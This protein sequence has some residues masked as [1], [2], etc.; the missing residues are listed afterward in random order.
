MDRMRMPMT[1]LT[2]RNLL[3]TLVVPGLG[4]VAMPWWILTNHGAAPPATQWYAV[5]VIV[6]GAAVYVACVWVFAVVGSGTPGPWDPPRHFVAVGPYRCVRNPIYLAALLVVLGEAWLFLSQALLVYAGVMAIVFHLFVI[7]YEE[8]TLRRA[9]GQTYV[10]YT[11]SVR[12]W[13]PVPVV[14]H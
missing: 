5:A 9:F 14:H 8:P 4:A 2:V 7:G 3:F 13:L 10:E 12:R 6:A 11:R 1:N